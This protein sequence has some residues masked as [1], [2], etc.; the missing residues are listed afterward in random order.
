MIRVVRLLADRSLQPK[1][2]AS[3]VD[4]AVVVENLPR[5]VAKMDEYVKLLTDHFEALVVS[6]ASDFK[7]RQVPATFH[8]ATMIIQSFFQVE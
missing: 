6:F 3:P 7:P 1:G 8:H 4:F 5:R 2:L